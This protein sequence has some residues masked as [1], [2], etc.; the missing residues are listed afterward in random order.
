MNYPRML[1]VGVLIA[2]LVYRAVQVGRI[3]R[4]FMSGYSPKRYR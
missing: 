4:A 2:L 3:V 1:A